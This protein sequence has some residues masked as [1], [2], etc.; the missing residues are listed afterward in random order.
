M[1]IELIDERGNRKRC[2][3]FP[4]LVEADA[5]VLAHPLGGEAEALGLQLVHRLP[6]ILHLPGLRRAFRDDRDDFLDVQLVA[7]GECD[8]FGQTLGDADDADLVH[9]L[10]ELARAGAADQRGHLGVGVDHRLR[11]LEFGR[12]A[13]AHDAEL[14]VDGAGLAARDRRVDEADAALFRLCMNFP[15]DSGRRRRVIDENRAALHARQGAVVPV[16][17]G[18]HVVVVADAHHH[19]VAILGGVARRCGVFSAVL[20]RP[21]LRL[22]GGAVVDRDVVAAFL[23]EMSGHRVAHDAQAEERDFR[24]RF[25]S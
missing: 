3:A 15:G 5:H 14:A 10:G 2:A 1:R 13:A 7:L 25:V 22:G 6:A 9:H 11:A 16:D 17:D 4:R 24:H 19:E 8:R 20:F 12:V 18:A 23:R 21:L